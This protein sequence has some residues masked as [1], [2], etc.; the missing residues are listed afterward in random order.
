MKEQ[1]KNISLDE[2]RIAFKNYLNQ[3]DYA[4][5]TRSTRLN[6]AFYLARNTDIDFIQLLMSDSFENEAKQ[7]VYNV[8]VRHSNSSNI[9][10]SVNGYL[11]HLKR[12]RSFIFNCDLTEYMAE[13]EIKQK[14]VSTSLSI[15]INEMIRKTEYY[16]Y[17]VNPNYTRYNSWKH[18]YEAF[19][20]FRGNPKKTEYLCL[21]L[22]FYLASWGMLRNS[23]LLNYDYYVHKP[24]IEAISNKRYDVLYD[25]NCEDIE[26]I[27]DVV[28]EIDKCYPA[29][30]T[31]T[32]TLAT[33]IILGVFGCVPAYDR[34]FVDGIRKNKIA[35]G[36]FS[37]KS[38]KQ[39]YAFYNN[40]PEFE[41]LRQKFISEGTYYTKMKIIDMCFWQIGLESD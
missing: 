16:H 32:D 2:L 19:R 22:A 3:C 6:D 41:K 8:L 39:L 1:L 30:I 17:S 29:N 4:E 34:Y 35:S 10:R 33:K 40:H 37:K 7:A 11:G 5:S 20:K 9:Q 36:S 15:D 38:L 28:S 14:R 25:D 24:F 23:A 13:N 31:K 18:C 26:T 12:L 27:F 21:Q